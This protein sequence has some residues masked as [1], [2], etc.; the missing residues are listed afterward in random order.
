MKLWLS[1]SESWKACPP[2]KFVVAVIFLQI[3]IITNFL[4]LPANLK[5]CQPETEFPTQVGTAEQISLQ[6]QEKED[7]DLQGVIP[8]AFPVWSEPFPCFVPD[9]HWWKTEVVRSPASRGFLFVKEMKTGSS[10]V[11]GVTLRIAQVMAKRLKKKF[12]ICKSR[13]D[14]SLAF[15]L[16]YG[17]RDRKKSFLWTV[18]REPNKRATSQF[19]HF[20]VSREKKEPSDENFISYLENDV[21]TNYY[22]RSLSTRTPYIVK[23]PRDPIEM[24]NEIMLDYDFIGI[25]ERMDESL[26]VLTMLLDLELTDVLYLSAKGNGGF[27][28]GKYDKTCVYIVPSYLSPSM[29]DYFSNDEDWKS[30]TKG[31]KYLY[32]AAQRSL[33]MTIDQLGRDKFN[34]K[35]SE[36]KR[37]RKLAEDSCKGQ[38]VY[39]CDA[40]GNRLQ[41]APGCLWNDS[42]CGSPCLD[43][44]V[45]NLTMSSQ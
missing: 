10:T 20:Q 39:P 9:L 38:V 43:K 5:S 33:D 41:R 15:K 37:L 8:R 42:G 25:T 45:A 17:K 21:F 6:H 13:F 2:R 30:R 4:V 29:K 27:D 26:V 12:N 35:L 3:A 32:R 11:T 14:H 31:D 24:A 1:W 18:I 23:K 44:V 28:D 40:G 36:Y 7:E 34:E 19:F 16:K 22:L